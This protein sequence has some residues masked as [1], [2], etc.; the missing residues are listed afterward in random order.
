MNDRPKLDPALQRSATETLAHTNEARRMIADLAKSRGV[1]IPPP[2]T[3]F[4]DIEEE[5][6]GMNERLDRAEQRERDRMPTNPEVHVHLGKPDSDS[7]NSAM[8]LR[9]PGGFSLRRAPSWLILVL[10]LACIVFAAMAYVVAKIA[11]NPVPTS[12]PVTAPAHS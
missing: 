8:S 7:P 6:T 12:L 11:T 1:P 9:G 2:P 3:G 4:E 5:I 10:G